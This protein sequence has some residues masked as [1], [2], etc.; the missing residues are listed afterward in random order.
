MAK[1]VP[2]WTSE[3]WALQHLEFQWGIVIEWNSCSQVFNS[4]GAKKNTA[5]RKVYTELKAK[6]CLVWR[7]FFLV[8]P[9]QAGIQSSENCVDSRLRGND[10]GRQSRFYAIT[11]FIKMGVEGWVLL[12]DF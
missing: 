5:V 3:G 2:Q 12:R 10:G 11:G 7:S 8:M 9:A 6:R 1:P 4:K